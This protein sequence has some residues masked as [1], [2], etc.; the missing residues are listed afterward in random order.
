[1]ET[2]SWLGQ[3]SARIEYDGGGDNVGDFEGCCRED[4]GD[5]NEYGIPLVVE[6]GERGAGDA[7]SGA[8]RS[9]RAHEATSQLDQIGLQP[10]IR[11]EINH[12][13]AM[14]QG[15]LGGGVPPT[16]EGTHS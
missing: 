13:N 7:E 15:I 6:Y 5:D 2:A 12:T 11:P 3:E 8:L 1:M 4:G 16:S 14:Y 10:I 9:A